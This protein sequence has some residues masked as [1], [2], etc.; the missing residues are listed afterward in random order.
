MNGEPGP[1]QA[2]EG[3]RQ[4]V[5][6]P[7]DPGSG[8]VNAASAV[9]IAI[10]VVAPLVCALGVLGGVGSFATV[11]HLASPYFGSQAWIVPVGVDLGI[12]ALLAW[13]L[14]AEYLGLA[15]PLLRWTAWAFIAAPVYLNIAAA[16][17]RR[18]VHA[19]KP[20]SPGV[21]VVESA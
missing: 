2:G 4:G 5:A 11:R 15:W 20:M 12:I 19:V 14:L 9:K 17:G 21:L 6:A 7:C 10:A 13:D 3:R 16:R 1:A 18:H 8:P